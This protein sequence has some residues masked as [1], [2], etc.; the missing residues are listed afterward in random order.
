MQYCHTLQRQEQRV[1]S[2]KSTKTQF[3]IKKTDK[4][5]IQ[6]YIYQEKTIIVNSPTTLAKLAQPRQ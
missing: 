6:K 2:L 1:I 3:K 4:E 5:Q